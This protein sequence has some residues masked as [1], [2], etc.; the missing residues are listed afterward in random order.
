VACYLGQ[1]QLPFG[2]TRTSPRQCIR[3]NSATGPFVTEGT[4]NK[5]TN[6][7]ELTWNV[8]ASYEQPINAA[9][10]GF[11]QINYFWRD[12]VNFSAAGDPNAVQEAY[13][14]LGAQLGVAAA[15]GK[16]R[17]ALFGKN[18]GDEKFVNNVIGQPVLGAT[19]V[20]SQFPSADAEQIVGISFEMSFGN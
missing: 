15:D 13:G 18:L 20:Y 19:G 14:L 12:D 16:W 6:A 3:I 2:T 5:L 9:L 7:P 17:I 1:T 4:G 10:K 11:A 8:S